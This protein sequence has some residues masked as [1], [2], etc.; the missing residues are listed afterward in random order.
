MK[1]LV[2]LLVTIAVVVGAT[3]AGY[4]YFENEIETRAGTS[5]GT[6]GGGGDDGG[7][8]GGG[9]TVPTSLPRQSQVIVQGTVTS[10][11]LE[12]ARVDSLPMPLVVTTPSRGNGS[13]GTF[14]NVQVDGQPTE[15]EWD[16]GQP[17][18]LGG[19]GGFL[20][21]GPLTIDADSTNTVIGLGKAPHG[22]AAGTYT[23]TSS[24]AVG[25]GGLGKAVDSV[26]FVA[27]NGSSVAFRGE[28][29]TTLPTRALAMRGTGNVVI[30]GDL[31]VIRPDGSQ[32]KIT[33]ATL[34][35][36]PFDVSITPG[37]SGLAVNGTLQGDVTTS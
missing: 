2:G 21:T 3:I 16:A 7:V 22:F 32:T 18:R 35:A 15:I 25:S 1:Y 33:S 28:A 19:D 17:L 27:T 20:V 36:G 5:A 37:G 26:S 13:G 6:S 12:G 11:H 14:Q 34:P 10:I 4:N 9:T 30:Q 24:V 29:S 23:I 31:T 8:I